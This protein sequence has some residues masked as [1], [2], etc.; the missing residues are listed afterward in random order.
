MIWGLPAL[1]I[2]V[3]VFSG[4]LAVFTRALCEESRE[5]AFGLISFGVCVSLTTALAIFAG[6]DVL[7][8]SFAGSWW[9]RLVVGLV[10]AV[11][12]E[13]ARAVMRS[14]WGSEALEL[15]G[16]IPPAGIFAIVCVFGAW[17]AAGAAAVNAL[18]AYVQGATEFPGG[19]TFIMTIFT[20]VT[21]T[22]DRAF[23][24]RL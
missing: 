6:P 23:G 8:C 9:N 4:L 15:M 5:G 22:F 17:T 24:K 18:P 1:F 10:L 11:L 3:G 20:F 12:N 7:G 19:L 14:Q 21:V 2:L 16:A 13:P